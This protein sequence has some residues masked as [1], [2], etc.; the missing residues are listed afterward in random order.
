MAEA[1]DS[2]LLKYYENFAPMRNTVRSLAEVPALPF[3]FVMDTKGELKSFQLDLDLLPE[4][5]TTEADPFPRMAAISQ[6]NDTGQMESKLT[7]VYENLVGGVFAINEVKIPKDVEFTREIDLGSG[8]TGKEF[9]TDWSDAA[10]M[11]FEIQGDVRLHIFVKGDFVVFSTSVE[12]SR[13][14]IETKQAIKLKAV[15]QNQAIV[16]Y[17]RVQGVTVGNS[18]RALFQLLG[19]SPDMMVLDLVSMG[20]GMGELCEIMNDMTWNST[21]S[22]GVRNSLFTL[23]FK[24][25]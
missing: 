11:G 9:L 6:V 14:I 1:I 19:N 16:D 3:G 24:D 5:F 25:K 4:P 13:E 18:F 10:G 2:I 17:G 12:L 8:V 22:N 20:D 7:E 15:E 23:D 21:Q